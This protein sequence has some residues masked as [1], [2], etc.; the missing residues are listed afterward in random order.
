MKSTTQTNSQFWLWHPPSC[1]SVAIE[2][3]SW[4]LHDVIV[5]VL[6]MKNEKRINGVQFL[7]DRLTEQL[8]SQSP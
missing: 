3:P 6:W 7:Q 4:L 5:S 2:T 1:H 8:P